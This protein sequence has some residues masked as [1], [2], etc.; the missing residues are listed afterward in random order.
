MTAPLDHLRKE[1][2]ALPPDQRVALAHALISSVKEVDKPY[3]ELS[4]DA[5]I[6]EEQAD[7]LNAEAS[8]VLGYQAALKRGE[9]YP[10][11]KP[12]ASDP[13]QQRVFVIISR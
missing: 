12:G 6:L 10:R 8:D 13:K 11:R 3:A 7:G 2:L 5:A 9:L 4:P 1:A